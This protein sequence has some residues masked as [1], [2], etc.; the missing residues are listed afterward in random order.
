MQNGVELKDWQISF[1]KTSAKDTIS[2]KTEYSPLPDQ[3]I[4]KNTVCFLAAERSAL[5]PTGFYG[6]G[7][8][9]L[10]YRTNPI[11]TLV[12]QF[13]CDYKSNRAPYGT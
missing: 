6:L 8:V 7:H 5:R 1:Q 2:N 10:S 4:R 11:G 12:P 9:F 13:F 3:E